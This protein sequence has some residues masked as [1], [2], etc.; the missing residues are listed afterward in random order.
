[1]F[2]RI[3]LGIVINFERDLLSHVLLARL[4]R[5]RRLT[6]S[7][8]DRLLAGEPLVPIDDDVGVGTIEFHQVRI[9]SRLLRAD[10]G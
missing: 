10:Q 3:K 5:N 8:E 4:H 9:A 1:M 2:S 6:R 7:L